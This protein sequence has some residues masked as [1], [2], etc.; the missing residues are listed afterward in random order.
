MFP[1]IDTVTMDTLTSWTEFANKDFKFFSGTATYSIDLPI[2]KKMLKQTDTRYV[3]S[4]GKVKNM[5]QVVVNGITLP[6][7]WK[8][9]FECDITDALVKGNNRIEVKVTNLWPNRMIGDEQEPDDI[10]WSEPLTYEFAPG[11]PVAGRYMAKYPD[12]LRLG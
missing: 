3:L 6:V 11:S 2:K 5:A 8:A 9:P 4:L 1:G 12:W 7:L 10:E